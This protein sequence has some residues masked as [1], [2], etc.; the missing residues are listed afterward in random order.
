[1]SSSAGNCPPGKITVPNEFHESDVVHRDRDA[2]LVLLRLRCRPKSC[3]A[4]YG[5]RRAGCRR[6][7]RRTRVALA[8]ERLESA[9]G[10][11]PVDLVRR[12]LPSPAAASRRCARSGILASLALRVRGLVATE[13]N[14]DDVDVVL[15]DRPSSA[16]RPSRSRCR[17][18]SF[19]A[20]GS[21]CPAPGRTSRSALPR[22]SCR[23]ARSM[24]RC[25]PSWGLGIARKI[26]PKRHRSTATLRNTASTRL[27]LGVGYL[28]FC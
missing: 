12:T 22:G 19:R 24:R 16:L 27:M 8:L 25:T 28:S 3:A 13:R 20:R 10:D 7:A 1:M 18:A 26:H 21:A 6:R 11:D 9:D 17:A 4:T 14:A 15:L 5:R 23:R 2:A